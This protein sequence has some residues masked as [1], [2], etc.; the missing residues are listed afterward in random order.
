MS[1]EESSLRALRK[2]PESLRRPAAGFASQVYGLD[3]NGRPKFWTARKGN[4]D[5]LLSIGTITPDLLTLGTHVSPTSSIPYAGAP[6]RAIRKWLEKNGEM[7]VPELSRNAERRQRVLKR[8]IREEAA[9]DAPKGLI[10]NALEAAGTM[11]AQVPLPATKAKAASGAARKFLGAI[12]EYLGPTIR[13]SKGA[14]LSGTLG[15]GLLGAASGEAPP[16]EKAGGGFMNSRGLKP[17]GA[18]RFGYGG[19][20]HYQAGQGPFGVT[21]ITMSAPSSGASTTVSNRL[22]NGQS[23]GTATPYSNTTRTSSG[24]QRAAPLSM[25]D[26]LN[27]GM[28]AAQKFYIADGGEVKRADAAISRANVAL[29]R[30][31]S[32]MDQ[33][34]PAAKKP[35]K[36]A[37]GGKVTLAA[38]ALKAI[39]EAVGHLQNRD[40]RNAIATL[41][42]SKEALAHPEVMKAQDELRYIEGRNQGT[43]RLQQ[44]VQPKTP[45]GLAMGGEVEEPESAADAE[46]P[47]M[48]YVEMQQLVAAIQSGRLTHEE[49]EEAQQRIEEIEQLL[50]A[51]GVQLPGFDGGGGEPAMP[52]PAQ[53]LAALGMGE[54]IE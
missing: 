24:R 26:Y 22:P 1:D 16:E 14:Y 17:R 45:L 5:D 50:G 44:L 23:T 10:E 38:N 54:G 7:L 49:E 9:L 32:R 6:M 12:P 34:K 11:G 19:G 18:L 21:R 30:L 33:Q 25:D 39:Q 35:A 40:V 51:M 37:D 29:N 20:V 13:P 28:R 43:K 46:D 3:E 42:N 36:K 2:L 47:K 4:I 41:R 52:D 27:Y 15:G 53:A 8:A 31:K 48:L